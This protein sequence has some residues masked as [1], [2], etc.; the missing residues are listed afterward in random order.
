[1]RPSEGCCGGRGRA[2]E[3]A[4]TYKTAAVTRGAL[5][6]TVAATGTVQPINQVAVGS[7]LS[8]ILRT[9]K[10]DYNDRVG[11]GDV[12]AEIDTDKLTAQ[13][14]RAR[15]LLDAARANVTQGEATVTETRTDLDRHDGA[16]RAKLEHLERPAGG[17][18]CL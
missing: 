2:S 7:E 18:G 13:A 1:M 10:V 4:L 5:T 14:N 9:V 3:S 6:I 16:G 17:A 8:G 12:L 11:A 15:A